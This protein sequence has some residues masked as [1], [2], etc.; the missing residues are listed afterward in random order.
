MTAN[1]A[2]SA[3]ERSAKH[4]RTAADLVA[5]WLLVEAEKVTK[6]RPTHT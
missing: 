4:R 6:F 3:V 5:G 1:A 2:E